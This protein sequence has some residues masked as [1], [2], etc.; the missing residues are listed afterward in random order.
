M[1]VV[2]AYNQHTNDMAIC[3]LLFRLDGS[4]NPI[5]FDIYTDTDTVVKQIDNL[6]KP[7]VKFVCCRVPK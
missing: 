2:T 4:F 7:S 1:T 6:S 3:C 5:A